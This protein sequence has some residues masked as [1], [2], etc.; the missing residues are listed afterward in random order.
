[1]RKKIYSFLIILL[2]G[3]SNAFS[4]HQHFI[5]PSGNDTLGDG[6][7]DNPWKTLNKLKCNLHPGDIGYIRG[8]I[9]YEYVT[10]DQFQGTEVSPIVVQAYNNEVVI[11]DGSD[12]N[13]DP[14]NVSQ[15]NDHLVKIASSYFTLKNVEIR[16]SPSASVAIFNHHVTLDKLHVHNGYATG[17]ACESSSYVTVQNCIVHDFFDWK[18]DGSGS[19]IGG[20]NAN[21]IAFDTN[22]VVGVGN[23]KILNNVV[24]NCSDDGIDTWKTVNNLIRGNICYDNG[25]VNLGNPNIISSLQDCYKNIQNGTFSNFDGDGRGFKVGGGNGS[26]YNTVINNVSYHNKTA[27]FDGNSGTNNKFYNNTSYNNIVG[28]TLLAQNDILRNNLAINCNTNFEYANPTVV[29]SLTNNSNNSWNL[30]IVDPY[31]IN[32]D[33]S[34]PMNFNLNPCSSAIDKGTNVGIPY[35]CKR[36]D[37]GALESNYCPINCIES[38]TKTSSV[39]P[40]N[41]YDYFDLLNVR[42]SEKEIVFKIDNKG[43]KSEDRILKIFSFTGEEIKSIIINSSEAIIPKDDL[44]RGIYIY[45]VLSNNEITNRGKFVIQ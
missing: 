12:V 1:M 18:C 27:G 19:Y 17:I 43:F 39:E 15:R 8:G 25:Y 14:Y 5:S 38:L 23:H 30:G 32:T 7:I 31:F 37:L 41:S 6:S 4:Q 10:F 13:V 45:Q 40:T 3:I 22:N 33:L 20:E 44:K 24:Y 28:F 21:G 34:M 42:Y 11:I 2:L 36:P 9:Y 29:P 35:K 26:G 16:Y